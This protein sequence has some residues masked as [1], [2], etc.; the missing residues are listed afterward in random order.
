MNEEQSKGL[1]PSTV[2]LDDLVSTF[3]KLR[4]INGSDTQSPEDRAHKRR[5]DWLLARSAVV[6]AG[7]VLFVSAYVLVNPWNKYSEDM[8]RVA[9]SALLSITTGLIGYSIKR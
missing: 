5:I 1:Q 8:Q 3:E 2:K 6:S 9:G 7:L 4:S